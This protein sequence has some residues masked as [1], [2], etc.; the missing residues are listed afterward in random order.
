MPHS[1]SNG[2]IERWLEYSKH[3]HDEFHRNG[4]DKHCVWLGARKL[5]I[6]KGQD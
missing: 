2:M 4:F 5:Q 6:P 1:V 3:L